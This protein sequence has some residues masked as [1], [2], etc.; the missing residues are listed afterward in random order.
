MAYAPGPPTRYSGIAPDTIQPTT[1]LSALT[2]TDSPPGPGLSRGTESV[3]QNSLPPPVWIY[4]PDWCLTRL[5]RRTLI[6]FITFKRQTSIDGQ[7][8]GLTGFS[9]LQ[10]A[11][12]CPLVGLRAHKTS[13]SSG[14]SDALHE[15]C[16]VGFARLCICTDR[17]HDRAC[18]ACKNKKT[19]RRRATGRTRKR[20]P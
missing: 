3:R 5:V 2:G 17:N 4:F 12:L 19:Y 6:K 20:C 1:K 18:P 14:T 16:D 9:L 10:I 8:T 13:V 15:V 11:I 7:A